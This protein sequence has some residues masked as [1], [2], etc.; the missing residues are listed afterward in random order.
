MILF[1]KPY[2]TYNEDDEQ[3]PDGYSFNVQIFRSLNGREWF[4]TGCGRYCRN[5]QEVQQYL[6]KAHLRW[7]EEV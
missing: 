1:E 2:I 6:K 4:Y 5:W 3:Q 7:G